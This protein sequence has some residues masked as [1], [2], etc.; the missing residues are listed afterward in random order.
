RG[1]QNPPDGRKVKGTIHWVSARHAVPAEV[2]LYDR[3]FSVENPDGGEG[4][5]LDHLNPESLTVV[6]GCQLEPALRDAAPGDPI[7]FER[8]GYFCVDAKD[9][10]PDAPVFNRTVGLRDSWAKAQK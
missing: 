4:D 10:T 8:L 2:R 3:L 9:S 6:T 5:F 1:G 7:Q